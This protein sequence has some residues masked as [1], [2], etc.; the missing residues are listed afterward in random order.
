MLAGVREAISQA[1]TVDE[2][3][4]SIGQWLPLHTG[5]AAGEMP[6]RDCLETVGGSHS[7][8]PDRLRS[9][10]ANG[11]GGMQSGVFIAACI[12]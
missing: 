2:M 11:F 5:L 9:L 6:Q 3:C 10:S 8:M 1:N 12:R 7:Y 4:Q